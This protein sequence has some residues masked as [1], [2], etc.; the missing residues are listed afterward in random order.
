[1][2]WIS[3]SFRMK[4]VMALL[5]SDWN[6]LGLVG[7]CHQLRRKLEE[8]WTAVVHSVGYTILSRD[9][10]GPQLIYYQFDFRP[11][12][13]T[14]GDGSG[15]CINQEGDAAASVCSRFWT[16]ATNESQKVWSCFHTI[17]RRRGASWNVKNTFLKN[18]QTNQKN[19]VLFAGWNWK[20]LR[21][22]VLDSAH[23][24]Y[25]HRL[26]IGNRIKDFTLHHI[27]E[28]LFSLQHFD[29]AEM[30]RETCWPQHICC[31]NH[32]S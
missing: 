8:V 3:F 30:L 28:Y 18:P 7:N 10:C 32:Q 22:D 15:G 2:S 23:H 16:N 21:W 12:G 19:L 24:L 17:G 5:H 29:S 6:G 26:N 13:G 25:W 11:F 9:S 31:F 14:D 1:M 4:V 27:G 20:Y